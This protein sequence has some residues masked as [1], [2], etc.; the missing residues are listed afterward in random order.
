MPRSLLAA[1]A[2]GLLV[3][4]ACERGSGSD[5]TVT[6]S[7][8]DAG[9]RCPGVDALDEVWTEQRRES[10]ASSWA[11]LQGEWPA[12]LLETI[13]A[14]V[15]ERGPS[16]RDAYAQACASER[17]AAMR[18]LDN[19]RWRLDAALTLAERDPEWAALIWP[20]IDAALASELG[21][22]AT[23]EPIAPSDEAGV[24]LEIA[25]LMRVELDG[26]ARAEALAAQLDSPPSPEDAPSTAAQALSKALSEALIA[27]HGDRAEDADAALRAAKDAAAS[28]GPR[29][30]AAVAGLEA[31]LA[32]SRAEVGASL[33]A[34]DRAVASARGQDQPWLLVEQL[35]ALGSL[36]LGLAH[37]PGAA[38]EPL[39][40]AIALSTRLAGADSPRAAEI[41]LTLA[42]ALTELGKIEAAY[43]L[44]TQARDS[45]LLHLGPD[46][47]QTLATVESIGRLFFAAGQPGEAQYAYLDLLDIYDHLYGPKHWRV[48]R[49][50]VELGDALMAMEQHEGAR[51]MYMEAITPLVKAL[52]PDDRAVIRSSIHL[53]IAELALGNIEEAE[54]HCGRGVNLV[55]A[56]AEGD[57]LADEAARCMDEIAK[58]SKRRK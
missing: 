26:R 8:A 34:M 33:A 23:D 24:E 54:K 29:A 41:Q 57:P 14:R 52:G 32:A 19:Q 44:L 27:S 58:A 39:T 43:D 17:E 5:E 22:V 40:E 28:L 37:D 20:E 1:A 25:R 3:S 50:K 48:A 15:R 7:A 4:P 16:W 56:L 35:H 42:A 36:R 53:G 49:V 30:E 51:T 45:F 2:L 6:P 9:P 11:E 46:H 55:K 10:L 18:C 12:Q 21:C 13:D 31:E 38:V 47:P